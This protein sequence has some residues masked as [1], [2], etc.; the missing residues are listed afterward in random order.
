VKVRQI[1]ERSPGD[2]LKGGSHWRDIM[3]AGYI[4]AF[5]GLLALQKRLA[6]GGAKTVREQWP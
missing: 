6:A 4:A 3:A 5:I 2:G 1:S